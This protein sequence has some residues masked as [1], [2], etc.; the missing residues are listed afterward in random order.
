M[1]ITAYLP[2][3]AFILAVSKNLK[4]KQLIFIGLIV[5]AQSFNAQDLTKLEFDLIKDDVN[6][7]VFSDINESNDFEVLIRKFNLSEADIEK[8]EH[9]ISNKKVEFTKKMDS[10]SHILPFYYLTNNPEELQLTIFSLTVKNPKSNEN[11]HRGE[12]HFVLTTTVNL[13]W[14]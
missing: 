3:T 11:F 1:K 12:Y 10:K 6:Q 14:S 4:M 13:K 5:L 8:V 7:T 2:A 9:L